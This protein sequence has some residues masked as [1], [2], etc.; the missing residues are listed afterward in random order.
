MEYDLVSESSFTALE[1]YKDQY[2]YYQGDTYNV[3][4]VVLDILQMIG[5]TNDKSE[6]TITQA[7]RYFHKL[8]N[9]IQKLNRIFP[10]PVDEAKG[11]ILDY[12]TVIK[13]LLYDPNL[14]EF[15]SDYM[16]AEQVRKNSQPQTSKLTRAKHLLEKSPIPTTTTTTINPLTSENKRLKARIKQLESLLT[17]K[18][19]ELNEAR[20]SS[21]SLDNNEME[22]TIKAYEAQNRAQKEDLLNNEVVIDDLLNK[23]KEAK[24]VNQ[25]QEEKPTASEPDYLKEAYNKTNQLVGQ[26]DKQVVTPVIKKVRSLF[27]RG[28]KS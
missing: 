25:M 15:P 9:L 12:L 10:A 26:V 28:D 5:E 20:I 21:P 2:Y 14:R 1:Q 17:S 3:R 22:N 19:K 16:V 18:Q 7:S 4:L 13:T 23:L 27:N 8:N 24:K 11:E 6:V